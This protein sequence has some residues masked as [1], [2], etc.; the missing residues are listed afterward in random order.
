[1][2]CYFY[3]IS[4]IS[5]LRKKMPKCTFWWIRPLVSTEFYMQPFHSDHSTTPLLNG[6]DSTK[7]ALRPLNPIYLIIQSVLLLLW[8]RDSI[9]SLFIWTKVYVL[10]GFHISRSKFSGDNTMALWPWI[11]I[12]SAI[13]PHRYFL[14]LHYCNT[15]NS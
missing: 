7:N 12:Q 6:F 4:H 1:M 5:M 13:D 10:P 11:K 14:F 9:C 2:V 15:W 3:I 8:W